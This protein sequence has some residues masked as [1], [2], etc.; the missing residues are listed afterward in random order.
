MPVA[1]KGTGGGSVTLDSGTASTDT[2]IS[3]PNANGT[4][5]YADS[6]NNVGI[7]TNDPGAPG[8]TI[9]LVINSS[10]TTI[11]KSQTSNTTTGAARFDFTTGTSFSYGIIAL[12]DS[13]GNPNWQFTVGSGVQAT[14]Y[15]SPLHVWRNVAGTERARIDSSGNFYMNSGYGSSAAAY[16]CRAWVNF[17]GTTASPST[18]RG[19]GNI[20]SVTKNGTGDYTIN[21]TN[22]MPDANYSTVV[23]GT[24]NYGSSYGVGAINSA[25]APSTSAV[26]VISL[27]NVS[28]AAYS[29]PVYYCV[30][31]FR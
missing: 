27:N 21:F 16:G 1:I 22:A 28:G 25:S 7:G 6:N 31:I 4:V 15:D 23:T 12:N 8:G 10:G 5:I 14:Y 9:N 19:S 24:I 11:V 26:R 13:S 30:S 29:D 20:S 3:L 18:I 2:T 17:N